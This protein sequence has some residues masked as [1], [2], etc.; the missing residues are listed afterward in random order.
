MKVYVVLKNGDFTE[1]RGPMLFHKAFVT[2]TKMIEYIN[3]IKCGIYGAE[4]NKGETF[5]EFC[6]NGKDGGWSGY[7]IHKVE[8]E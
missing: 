4:P 2:K 8:A 5:Y 7:E 6:T 1:G 3:S